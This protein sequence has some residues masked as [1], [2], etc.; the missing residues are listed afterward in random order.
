[1]KRSFKEQTEHDKLV[2]RVA[3][4]YMSQEWKVDADISGYSKPR[5]LYGRR[6]DVIAV[7]GRK[8][9]VIEVETPSSYDSDSGQRK[10]FRRF[11]SH[12]QSRNFRTRIT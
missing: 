1:M 2:R 6:P 3:A 5:T 11:T 8:M 4:G 7:H 10:A 12:S 9:R